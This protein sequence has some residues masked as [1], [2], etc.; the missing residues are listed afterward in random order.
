MWDALV[1]PARKIRVGNKLYFGEND[2]LIAEVVDNTTSRGRTIRFI[3]DGDDEGYRQALFQFG[4]TPLPKELGRGVQPEDENRYQTIFASRVG[5]VAAPTAGM[6]FSTA[7]LKR[8]E[9]MGI[10]APQIT[11]HVG[12]VFSSLSKW[13]TSPN[14]NPNLNI[15]KWT[16]LLQQPLTAVWNRS[17]GYVP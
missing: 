7:V 4:E 17:I 6:H 9:L 13:K 8:L 11:L 3:Y 1:D 12:L 16:K 10:E 2:E 15:L 5:A 14:T